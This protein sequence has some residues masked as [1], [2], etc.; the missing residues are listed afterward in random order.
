MDD[1]TRAALWAPWRLD[2]IKDPGRKDP[3]ANSAGCFLCDLAADPG[4]D[5]ERFVVAR[6]GPAVAVLNR[7]PYNNGHTLVAPLEHRGD[8]T[9]LTARQSA[10][11]QSLLTDLTAVLRDLLGAQGFN[12]GL[13]LGAVAGAGLPGHLHWHLVPR[14][15]GDGNFMS[16]TAGTDV[17]PQSLAALHALLTADPRLKDPA[18][19]EPAS[20][21]PASGEPASG[22]PASGEPASG[23]PASRTGEAAPAA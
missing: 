20:G 15:A 10:A 16:V 19:G 4:G 8:L 3:P 6:R 21:E 7:F 17:I 23:G 18:S 12:A 22:D 13:N 14:W 5:A 1:R 11:C 9:E 2:Y